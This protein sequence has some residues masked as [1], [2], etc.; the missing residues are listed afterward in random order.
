MIMI[1][2][3][4]ILLPV[5]MLVFGANLCA[6]QAAKGKADGKQPNNGKKIIVPMVYLGHSKNTGG[7][8]KKSE[9]DELLKQGLTS[10]DSLGNN[11]KVVGFQFSYAE[12]NVYEDSMG[13]LQM[14]MDYSYE[15]CPGDTITSS[16]SSSIYDRTKPGDTL[17]FDRVSLVKLP[18]KQG[19]AVSESNPVAGRAMKFYIVK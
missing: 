17:Y 10:A 2:T 11:Y 13:N 4:K 1:R 16:I 6:Q 7:P 15:F 19:D 3:A 9:F 12:R 14:M 5:L 18:K 8:I